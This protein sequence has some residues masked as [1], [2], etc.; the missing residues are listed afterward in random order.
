MLLS[1]ETIIIIIINKVLIKVTLN[2]DIAG[3][4][5]IV[6]ELQNVCGYLIVSLLRMSLTKECAVL[7][8]NTLHLQTVFVS[9][10]F[11][12]LLVVFFLL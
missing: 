5:Y 10:L 3:A 8:S 12:C 4:L 6:T 2:K 1:C 11:K 9:C 7:N